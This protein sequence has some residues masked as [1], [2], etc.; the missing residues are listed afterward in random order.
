MNNDF[1]IITDEDHKYTLVKYL[2][3]QEVLDKGP[4]AEAVVDFIKAFPKELI[5]TEIDPDDATD[6]HTNSFKK[7]MKLLTKDDKWYD[8][9]AFLEDT[10][11]IELEDLTDEEWNAY[12]RNKR[13][14]DARARAKKQELK[15][16]KK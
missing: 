8:V 11:F 16:K 6:F 2:S 3:L 1:T 12:W 14:R 5:L 9:V 7:L 4:C 13:R 10:G 15:K